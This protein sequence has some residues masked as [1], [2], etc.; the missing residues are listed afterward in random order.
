MSLINVIQS[1][2]SHEVFESLVIVSRKYILGYVSLGE[3]ESGF[4]DPKTDFAFL[5]PNSQT[6]FESVESIL[7][8][9]SKDQIRILGIHDLER[10]FWKGFEKNTCIQ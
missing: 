9:D 5:Y 7:R 4:L 8:K 3:S 2:M 1:R 10:F 6:D